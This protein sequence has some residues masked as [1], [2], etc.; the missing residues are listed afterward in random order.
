M[1]GSR[2][3]QENKQHPRKEGEEGVCGDSR[4][5]RCPV[6]PVLEWLYK[7]ICGAWR[8]RPPRK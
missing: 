3:I 6:G 4:A 5:E 1:G 8:T 2:K 7:T